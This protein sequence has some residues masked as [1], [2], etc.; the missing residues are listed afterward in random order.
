MT[1]TL[2]AKQQHLDEL[3]RGLGRTLVAYSGCVDSAYLAWDA[4]RVLAHDMLA[5][6]AD[7]PRLARY[8]LLDAEAFAEEQR[9]PLEIIRTDEMER[10]EY[11]RND[12]NRCFHCKDELFAAMHKFAGE[13]GFQ[14][15]A[16]GVN[17]DD[18]GDFRPGQAA[19]S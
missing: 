14:S 9:I 5:V 18:Q 17:V 6:N 8:Q 2:E 12:R 16:Y 10:P 13:H 3:L 19:A 4:H 1:S 15:I 11:V 7:T